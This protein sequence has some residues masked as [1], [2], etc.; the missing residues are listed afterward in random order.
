[1]TNNF[2]GRYHWYYLIM[3]HWLNILTFIFFANFL[4]KKTARN[5]ISFF[6]V[7]ITASIST[8][9]AGEKAPFVWLIMG[10]FLVGCLVLNNKKIPIKA[11]ALF[12]LTVFLI[13]TF[14][15]TV[16]SGFKSVGPALLAVFSRAFTGDI[17]PL[18][19]YLDYFPNVKSFLYGASFPNPAGIFPIE[20]FNLA[21]EIAN[22]AV[23]QIVK[24][25]LVGTMPTA[26]W[27]DVYANFG[28]LGL[29]IIPFWVGIFVGL[30]SLL[31]SKIND[32]VIKFGFLVWLIFHY[33]KL[34]YSG[35][36]SLIIDFYLFGA[37]FLLCLIYCLPKIIDRIFLLFFSKFNSKPKN[38]YE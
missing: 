16:F 23:P 19:F 37:V 10:L 3:R 32:S 11:T 21:V 18:Y 30:T 6:I 4:V 24:L 33:K 36:G 27:G 13:L 20:Q 1:M 7:F 5:L 17:T 38:N 12:S 25:G 22:W 2:S 31:V 28:R 15:F 29:I 14:I 26:F 9:I 8:L 35:I 34:A